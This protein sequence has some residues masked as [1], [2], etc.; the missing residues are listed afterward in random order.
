MCSK[1][2]R[3]S[4]YLK[5]IILGGTGGSGTKNGY[6]EAR[7]LVRYGNSVKGAESRDSGVRRIWS[8]SQRITSLGEGVSDAASTLWVAPS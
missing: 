7:V 5:Y 8:Q 4:V 1:C 3:I 2:Q 6:T